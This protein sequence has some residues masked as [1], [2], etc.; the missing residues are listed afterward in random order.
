ME[1][2]TD[3]NPYYINSQSDHDDSGN[4][5]YNLFL[6][7]EFL[8]DI[9][10]P[11][12]LKLFRVVLSGFLYTDKHTNFPQTNIYYSDYNN[13]ENI[14]C[15]RTT[16]TDVAYPNSSLKRVLH[17][18]S[19]DGNEIGWR[20]TI[21]KDDVLICHYFNQEISAY[22]GGNDTNEI[23]Y[24]LYD[25]VEPAGTSIYTPEV[26]EGSEITPAA[27]TR[28]VYKT[29]AANKIAAIGRTRGTD[30]SLFNYT[31]NWFYFNLQGYDVKCRFKT[32]SQEETDSG[33]TDNTE[34]SRFAD[35]HFHTTGIVTGDLSTDTYP[36]N[37][38]DAHD[39]FVAG[40][41]ANTETC[42]QTDMSQRVSASDLGDNLPENSDIV[43]L[44]SGAVVDSS[45]DAVFNY[46]G[47][48]YKDHMAELTSTENKRIIL[49]DKFLDKG[50]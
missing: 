5:I 41:K 46:N 43:V 7:N 25:I 35:V 38:R 1:N 47:S 45:G 50:V 6:T 27:F 3:Y 37:M 29:I 20:S 31:H 11:Q 33:Y 44:P 4:P 22:T 24:F 26:P 40:I 42:R 21:V 48:D 13:I 49:E 17:S 8:R 2:L 32:P 23:I 10:K 16:K 19:F 18:A 12:T 28:P 15:G 14:A 39:R 9:N 30:P 34:S 36:P